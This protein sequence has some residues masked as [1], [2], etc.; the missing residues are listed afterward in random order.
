M[1]FNA[2][3]IAEILNGKVHGEIGA[4]VTD[5]AKI[6]KAS[7]G[8]ITFL[9]NP[10][11]QDFLYTTEATIAL[12]NTDFEPLKDLPNTLTLIKV[13]NAYESLAKLLTVYNEMKTSKEGIEDPVFIHPTAKIG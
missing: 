5:F 10:K 4:V 11:Y 9:S 7:K 1:E 8:T 13:D 6:E 2:G 3:Q 12:V